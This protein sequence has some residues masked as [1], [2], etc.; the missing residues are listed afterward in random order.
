MS[1]DERKMAEDVDVAVGVILFFVGLF[2]EI[3]EFEF[4]YQAYR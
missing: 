3:H 2:M 1:E 4:R